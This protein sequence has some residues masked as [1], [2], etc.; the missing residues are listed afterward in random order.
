M[1]NLDDAHDLLGRY[2]QLDVGRRMDAGGQAILEEVRTRALVAI[3]DQ[4]RAANLLEVNR[5]LWESEVAVKDTAPV[6]A[7][8]YRLRRSAGKRLAM[9]II[10]LPDPTVEGDEG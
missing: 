10:D 3:A 1:T 6:A 4:L 5:Q 7:E 9:D 8:R 2:D